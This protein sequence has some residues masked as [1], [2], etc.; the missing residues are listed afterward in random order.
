MDRY[1]VSL[2]RSYQMRDIANYARIEVK[3]EVAIKLLK[4]NE[5]VEEV[6]A[7]T[8]LSRE[9]VIKLLSKHPKS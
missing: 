5:P 3:E 9:Q 1:A 2:E 6:V 4:R 8:G 7:L